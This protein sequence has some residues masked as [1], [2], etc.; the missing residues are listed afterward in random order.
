LKV[1]LIADVHANLPALEAVMK[2]A[3]G[4]GCEAFWNAGDSVGYGAF[5]EEVVTLLRRHAVNVVG[6]YDRKVLDVKKKGGFR[7]QAGMPEKQMAFNWAYEN[8]SEESRRW[9]RSLPEQLRM[10]VEGKKVLLL[11]A[12]PLSPKEHLS[13]ETPLSRFEALAE[14]ADADL[15]VCG[16]SHRPFTLRAKGTVFVNPGSVGRPDDEDARASYAT[17]FLRKGVFRLCHYRVEYDVERA[18]DEARRRGLPEPF[19]QMLLRGTDLGSVLAEDEPPCGSE[20]TTRASAG[21]LLDSAR[22]LAE[23]CG[24]EEGHARQ[25]ERLALELFDLLR[26]VHGLGEPERLWLQCASILHDIGWIEGG[27]GHHKTSQRLIQ[28]SPLLEGFSSRE[29]RI[30]GAIARYHRGSLPRESHFHYQAICEKDRFTI[31]E[32]ASLLR[33]ADGM[34]SSHGAIVREIGL[35]LEG[36][37]LLLECRVSSPAFCERESAE[38]KKDLFELTF[39]REL[40]IE[41]IQA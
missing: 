20:R 2:H 31:R 8:L 7:K 4:K 32:L 13:K 36:S 18:A 37:R 41:W 22:K 33:L 34:D 24:A 28:D 15:V 14:A 5:P 1:A 17:V 25:V 40:K 23:V 38:K 35:R 26:P 39:G 10:E 16:H 27:S 12:S 29:R 9:L 30:I 21:E 19:A 3:W 11:H 6:N